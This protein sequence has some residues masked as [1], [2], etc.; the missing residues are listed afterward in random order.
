MPVTFL[1]ILAQTSKWHL[2]LKM[3]VSR[4]GPGRRPVVLEPNSVT[5]TVQQKTPGSF[6]R[7]A[8]PKPHSQR[9]WFSQSGPASASL[10]N[11]FKLWENTHK[12]KF[13]SLDIFTCAR[14]WHLIHS[15]CYK[16]ITTLHPPELILQNLQCP[17]NNSSPLIAPPHQGLSPG[18]WLFSR[19]LV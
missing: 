6:Y 2:V 7:M 9:V 17:L 4:G 14:Q 18:I 19:Y 13:P 3:S 10:K 1:F 5:P 15:Q 16:T 11:D 12:I 8:E